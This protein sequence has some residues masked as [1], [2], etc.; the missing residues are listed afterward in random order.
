MQTPIMAVS[1]IVQTHATLALPNTTAEMLTSVE[2]L[3][4]GPIHISFSQRFFASIHT[5]ALGSQSQYLST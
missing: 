1:T 4:S 2:L 5:I 3:S